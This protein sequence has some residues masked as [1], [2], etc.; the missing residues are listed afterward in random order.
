MT[1]NELVQIA[2]RHLTAMSDAMIAACVRKALETGERLDIPARK[3]PTA[4][5]GLHA[6]QIILDEM[7][8]EDWRRM[9]EG[10][11]ESRAA[12]VNTR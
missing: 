3:R 5:R 11:R 12:H 2:A 8:D 1:I 7:D 10:N 6:A 9:C 4:Q